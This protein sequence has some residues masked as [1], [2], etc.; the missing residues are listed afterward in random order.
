MFALPKTSE[1]IGLVCLLLPQIALSHSVKQSFGTY[2]DNG[3]RDRQ[4]IG[5]SM[6][7]DYEHQSEWLS[8]SNYGIN[9][10]RDY[11][12]NKR[13]ADEDSKNERQL[14]QG[15]Q[16]VNDSFSTNIA[17]TWSRLTETRILGAV[18][19]DETVS[20]KT[21]GL[22]V[23]RWFVHEVLQV[24]VDVSRTFVEKP[25]QETLDLDA[26]VIT[27]PANVDAT[28][29]TLG[30]KHL[31]TSKTIANYSYTQVLATDR[32]PAHTMAAGVRQFIAPL[33][34]AL[35]GNLARMLNRGPVSTET[36]KGEAAAWQGE[37]AYLQNLW[38]GARV[39]L[40][41]RA[42]VED[43][44][45]RASQSEKTYGSDTVSLNAVQEIPKGALAG[46]RPMSVEAGASRYVNNDRVS[47]NTYEMGLAAQF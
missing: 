43:E 14:Y 26:E 22:G 38:Q 3:G 37:I 7:L 33:N 41:Y 46:G 28:G 5:L 27:L 12:Q 18:S 42:Y 2:E 16:R 1:V 11:Y 21:A 13:A 6:G 31:A 15:G 45:T 20:A 44:V 30:I 35:H 9:A 47:A 4:R 39:R 25:P 34:G 36:K 10:T 17:Q 8:S 40:G 23:G 19:K 24:N 32:P 29:T